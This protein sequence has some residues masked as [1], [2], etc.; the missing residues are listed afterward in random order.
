MER[1]PALCSVS[2]KRPSER[3]LH[4]QPHPRVT[5]HRS[6]WILASWGGNGDSKGS[7]P[8]RVW[9]QRPGSGLESAPHQQLAPRSPQPAQPQ[10]PGLQNLGLVG[11]ARCPARRLARAVSARLAAAGKQLVCGPVCTP[12]ASRAPFEETSEPRDGTQRN[13]LPSPPLVPLWRGQRPSGPLPRS[14]GCDP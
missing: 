6:P 12:P 1:G 7:W 11:A 9:N 13:A 2:G 4:P 10:F 8:K 5:D 3:V 14:P